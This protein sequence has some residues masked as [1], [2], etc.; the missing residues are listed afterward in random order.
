MCMEKDLGLGQFNDIDSF[1]ESKLKRLDESKAGFDLLFEMMFSERENLMYEKSEG[2]RI[3]QTTYGEAREDI[4]RLANTLKGTLAL[5]EGSVVGLSMNNSLLWIEMFWAILI[6]GYRPLLMN[7]RLSGSSLEQ[8][9]K[10]CG[11]AAV[12]SDGREYSVRT[13]LA[14]SIKKAD[15]AYTPDVFGEELMVMSSGTSEH[16]KICAYSA[17]EFR[18]QMHDTYQ[19]I[20]ECAVAKRH[21]DGHIKQLCF[22]PFYHVFGLFAMYIWFGFFSRAFV[23]LRDMQPQTIVNTIKR[24]KVTHIFAVPLFW[25]TVYDQAIKTIKN[26][27]EKTY[28]KFLKGMKISRKLS[29]T[30]ALCRAFSKKAF[31]EVRENLFGE[32]ICF[33]ISGGSAIRPEVIRFFNAIGY[34]LADGYGM[35]EIGITSVELSEDA[36]VLNSC[37]VGRPMT[38]AEYKI[39]DSGELLVRG[40]VIAKYI[41]EDGKKTVTDK[42]EWF[43]THDLAVCENGRYRILGRTDDLIVS[44]NGEN[45]NPNLVEPQLRIPGTNEVCLTTDGKTPTL[46]VSVNR[47]TTAQRF[48]TLDKEL[49]DKIAALN[50]RGQIG[51][52]VYIYDPLMTG[53]EFKLNRRRLASDLREGRLNVADP[54]SAGSEEEQDEL[55]LHLRQVIAAALGRDLSEVAPQSDFFADL[56]GT[57]LD[58]FAVI[59][60]LQE[61]FSVAFPQSDGKSLSTVRELYDFIKAAQNDV[62]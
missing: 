46:L 18:Y 56:G 22:L 54:S 45:L 58:Y 20:K 32:S 44:A 60:K 39:N 23:E 36:R 21:Y 8:A 16:I 9:L 40:K 13:V 11:A 53:D 47:Y 42:N 52:I 19:I 24:H 26:R 55:M 3:R 38:Y 37:S 17:E 28:N 15:K 49:K 34:H 12:I 6:S 10:D 57:S 27:G 5:P 31:K 2:Y 33:L 61:D 43:N 14:E 51:R 35:T 4:L 62:Y 25:E 59:A 30:P 7:L 41:I 50:L 48:E 29:K 1:V